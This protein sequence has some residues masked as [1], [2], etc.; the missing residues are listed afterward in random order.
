MSTRLYALL[1]VIL[2]VAVA[3]ESDSGQESTT[4]APSS[5]VAD[6]APTTV[7]PTTVPPTTAPPETAP[8]TTLPEGTEELPEEVRR[9]LAELITVTEQ[10]RQL[11]FQEPPNVVV[12][13]NEELAER[14]RDQLTEDLEDLP[15]DQALY[16][17]LGLIEDDMDLEALYTDLYS[18]QVAGF[19]DGEEA[20]LVVPRAEEGF[21]SL[22]RATLV[23]E[24]T[25]ALTDQHYQFHD[26]YSALLDEDRFD[27]AAAFQALIE[28]DA[29]LAE[30]FYL[31]GLSAEE[32]AA[33]FNESFGVD[34]EVFESAPRF[35]RDALVFPYDSGFLFI[36]RLFQ[37]GGFEAIADAYAA[38]PTST[39]QIMDPEDYPA[40]QPIDVEVESLALEGFDLEYES[41][42]GELSFALM[43][44][45]ILG[46]DTSDTAAGGWGGD[47]YQLH[48]D[49]SDVVLVLHY[50]GD[51]E[52]DGQELEGALVQYVEAGMDTGEAEDYED[53]VAYRGEDA[54]W[55]RADGSE[56]IFVA[57]SAADSLDSIVTAGLAS[58]DAE[59]S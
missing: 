42:W 27:E 32:Q 52:S 36:D 10:V 30:L 48:F 11:E 31:Q 9:E 47:A 56:V 45:Q 54:A 50:R 40:D 13:T 37:T 4:A 23:H 29:V 53:G 34:Q 21:T 58:G 1:A 33:F 20:E 18:E 22:Q 28:G 16:R 2:L 15:A 39:E 26:R 19:Y 17:L 49:G 59:E 12:V 6:G 55:I 25:H 57:V 24:L 35:I 3:C 14:V 43:F 38:P 41:T 7:P 8:Q 46:T 5:P 51:S 44:D